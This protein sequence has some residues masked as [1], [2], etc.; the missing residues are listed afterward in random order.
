MIGSSWKTT[1]TVMTSIA[2]LTLVFCAFGIRHASAQNS[3]LLRISEKEQMLNHTDPV[4]GIPDPAWAHSLMWDT[5]VERMIDRN[6]PYIELTNTSPV[7]GDAITDLHLT[8][9][10]SHNAQ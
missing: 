1:R 6:M 7:G 10:D 3:W 2:C 4:T 9:E 8:I 5:A